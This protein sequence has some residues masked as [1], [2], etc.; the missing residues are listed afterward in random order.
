MKKIRQ[1][2]LIILKGKHASHRSNGVIRY[3]QQGEMITIIDD[4]HLGARQ[5]RTFRGSPWE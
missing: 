1:W 5:Y 3:F 2:S 4:L